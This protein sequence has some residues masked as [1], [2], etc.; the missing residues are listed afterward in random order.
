MKLDRNTNKGGSG[1][2]A[3]VKMRRVRELREAL[4]HQRQTFGQSSDLSYEIV[5]N[6]IATLADFGVLDDSEAE[7]EGEFFVIRLRDK[8]AREALIAYA[9]AANVDDPEYAD[10]VMALAARAGPN[11]PF[12]KRPD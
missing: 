6:S 5:R 8:Y 7:S 3:L 4:D 12:M 1:K 9:F 2:Y 11:S 10:E